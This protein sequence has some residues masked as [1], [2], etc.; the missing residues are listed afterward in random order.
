[1]TD[2]LE[3]LAADTRLQLFLEAAADE[4]ESWHEDIGEMAPTDAYRGTD[5]THSTRVESPLRFLQSAVYELHT[6]SSWYTLVIQQQLIAWLRTANRDVAPSK[7]ELDEIK[8][9]GV[10]KRELLADMYVAHHACERF[11]TEILGINLETWL[12][13]PSRGISA[14]ATRTGYLNDD[15]MLK[16]TEEHLADN[17]QSDEFDEDDDLLAEAVALRYERFAGT[18]EEAVPSIRS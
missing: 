8:E 2:S 10:S 6:R 11:A 17:L 16:R 15:S 9:R 3:E 1:M 13:N 18:W 4:N 14:T 7:D 5:P 12:E